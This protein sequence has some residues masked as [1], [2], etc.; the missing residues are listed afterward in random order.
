MPKPDPKCFAC[1]NAGYLHM[2]AMGSDTEIVLP[3]TECVEG[4][5]YASFLRKLSSSPP[6]EGEAS[7]VDAKGHA[8]DD[9]RE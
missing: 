2:L 8:D 6:P 3:C 1:N 5:R 4:K 9:V 7:P